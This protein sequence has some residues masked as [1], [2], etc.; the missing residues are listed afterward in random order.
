V[1]TRFLASALSA[2]VCSSAS[3]AAPGQ[4]AASGDQPAATPGQAAAEPSRLTL[5]EAIRMALEHNQSLLATRTTL[6]QSRAQ[7]TTAG[8]R[9]NP[10]LSGSWQS[11]PFFHPADN[12]AVTSAG[13]SY[14]FELGKRGPRVQAAKDATEVTRSQIGDSE[15]TL[16]FQVASQFIS[17]QLAESTVEVTAQNLKSFQDAMEIS[18]A[19]YKSGGLAENDYLKIKLQL[20][21]FQTDVQAALLARAQALSDLRQTL[22]Y[23]VVAQGFDVSGPFEYQPVQVELERL[24]KLAEGS[25][26]DLRAASQGLAAAESQVALAEVNARPNLTL[27]ASY[28]NYAGQSSS[29]LGV[30]V[31]LPIFDRNQ[32]EIARTRAALLQAQHQ[33]AGALGQV[34]TD[35]KDA[36]EALQSS[37]RVARYYQ[38]GY[39]EVALKSRDISE[40]S[41]RRGASSLLDLL[42]AERSYR[43]TQLAWRQA[44]AAHLTAIEQVRQA[45]AARKL[46]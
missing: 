7:E 6:E 45:V 15:R 10:V 35:V 34:R 19:R 1:K 26:P 5:D 20:L 16:V 23:D 3:G 32:G 25:R 13:L 33:Y 8:L 40:Y 17:V 36:F 39:L 28:S 2:L 29:I 46:E 44:I 22:G 37:D 42:D 41:Y 31:P 43:A 38:G 18:E 11:P 14:E 30:S 21:Q 27:S 9:P 24:L 12:A 4:P